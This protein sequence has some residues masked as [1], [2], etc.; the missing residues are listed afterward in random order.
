M[1]YIPPT[2]PYEL[3]ELVSDLVRL[4]RY[5]LKPSGRLVFF[6]PTVT[7][8][9]EV[10]DIDGMLCEGME[11]IANSV[12][13]FGSWGRRVGGSFNF[14]YFRERGLTPGVVDHDPESRRGGLCAS[15]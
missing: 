3:S 7:D 15:V 2:Q 4:A 8:E 14:V 9:Y 6:L 12:Q 10:V 5:L 13:E 11:V 1:S